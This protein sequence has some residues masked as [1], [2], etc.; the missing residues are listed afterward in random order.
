MR[1]AEISRKTKETDIKIELNLDG[2][3][4]FEGFT[5]SG[6]FNHMLESFAKH[7]GFDLVVEAKGDKEV[8]A[9]HTVEDTGI[10]LGKAFAKA[11][12]DK[13]GIRRFGDAIVPMDEALVMAAVDISGRGSCFIEGKFPGYT[14]GDFP[15]ELV[16]EFFIAFSREAGVTLHIRVLSGKSLHHTIEATFKAVA[17]ALKEAVSIEGGDIPSTKGLL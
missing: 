7:S 6:F 3:G 9:H 10:V 5:V 16:E 1:K 15:A 14:V 11:L 17:R 2:K 12:E 13:R 4:Y 8:D